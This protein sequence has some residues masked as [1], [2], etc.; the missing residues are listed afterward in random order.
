MKWTAVAAVAGLRWTG[1]PVYQE[2]QLLIIPSGQWLVVEAC[3]GI[4]YLM[5]TLMAGAL[6]A[7]LNYRSTKRRLLFMLL[8][9]V[10]PI[11]ANWM[12][13]YMI[14]MIG[15][16]SGNTL[17]V[18]VDH[19]LYGWVFFGIVVFALF[20]FGARW[21]EPDAEPDAKAAAALR[22]GGAGAAPAPAWWPPVV[23]LLAVAVLQLPMWWLDRQTSTQVARAPVSLQPLQLGGNW[24]ARPAPS[25]SWTPSYSGAAAQL[26]QAFAGADGEVVVNLQYYRGQ[27]YGAKLV[28]SENAW[29]RG[30]SDWQINAQG[31]ARTDA[32][33]ALQW[34]RAHIA[35]TDYARTLGGSRQHLLGWQVYWIGGHLTHSQVE[36]KLWQGWLALTGQPDDA[37]AIILF[38]PGKDQAAGDARL[39]AFV[40]AELGPILK[41]LDR[42]R[43]VVGDAE[44]SGT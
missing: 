17:A 3:G 10:V 21:S 20:A 9:L 25:L 32:P 1:I 40:E 7:Y 43:A 36:A 38:T 33:V 11:V 39:R 15:H 29:I 6:F 8:A 13:A 4:R 18:G 22:H 5:S 30:K 31:L 37:A 26:N 14:I 23:A 2:G 19:L 28:S 24:R 42:T 27:N 12:R 41:S 16:L 44:K 34:N 35:Q